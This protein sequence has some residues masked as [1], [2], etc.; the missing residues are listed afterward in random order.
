M[1]NSTIWQSI[2]E[3]ADHIKSFPGKIKS[4]SWNVDVPGNIQIFDTFEEFDVISIQCT[5]KLT[6]FNFT[7][8]DGFIHSD[9]LLDDLGDLIKLYL[10]PIVAAIFSKRNKR[11]ITIGHF[12]QTL[13]GKIATTKD[14]SKW[15]GNKENLIHSHR[16]RALCDGILVGKNT[17]Q[18]D[19]P[20][21]DV[22]HVNGPN[23]KKIIIGTESEEI[24]NCLANRKDDI[25]AVVSQACNLKSNIDQ[26]QLNQ[27]PSGYFNCS[28]ILAALYD[29]GLK[30]IYIEG[31]PKTTSK[32]IQD[33]CLDFLQIHISPMIFGSGKDAFSLPA[34]ANVSEAISFYNYDF[35][36]IGRA[37]MFAGVLNKL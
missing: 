27:Q 17:F 7:V 35:Y 29:Y 20:S 36:K 8:Q 15:I 13:D 37:P 6:K 12:A 4:I 23:P 14:D 30:T 24:Q 2:L 5:Y 9:Q 18:I 32:F 26:I 3:L 22:R 11:S 33:G 31:G 19:N 16:M 34:I 28:E 21:L 25:V 1:L 10:Q